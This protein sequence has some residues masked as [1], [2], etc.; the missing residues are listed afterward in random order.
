MRIAAIVNVIVLTCDVFAWGNE[1]YP[2]IDGA[3]DDGFLVCSEYTT[4]AS[5]FGTYYDR[6]GDQHCRSHIGKYSS[7]ARNTG[8]FWK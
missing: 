6:F 7:R 3:H 2:H 8:E 5:M 1:Q 4:Y